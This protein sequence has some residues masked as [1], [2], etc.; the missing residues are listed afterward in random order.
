M[1]ALELSRL[2]KAGASGPV[3]VTP[4]LFQ[5]WPT[6]A[7]MATAQVPDIEDIIRVLGLAP[8]KAKNLSAMSK[9]GSH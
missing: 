4:E 1:F 3:E 6:A 5:K 8:T 9:V 7:D 2:N